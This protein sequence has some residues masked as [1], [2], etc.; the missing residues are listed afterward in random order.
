MRFDDSERA[1]SGASRLVGKDQ[2]VFLHGGTLARYDLK[3]K[4]QVW[5]QKL[6]TQQQVADLVKSEDEENARE[7]AKYGRD[8]GGAMLSGQHEKMVRDA[9]EG[10]L[11]LRVSGENV[12]IG[13]Y[14]PADERGGY[15]SRRPTTS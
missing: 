15:F 13:K 6:V 12:W 1:H 9:L 5:Q 10:A 4:K 14:R 2:I 8:I 7:S 11:K 3:T